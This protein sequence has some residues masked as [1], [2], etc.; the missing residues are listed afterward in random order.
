MVVKKQ[1]DRNEE[2]EIKTELHVVRRE[3]KKEAEK[4]KIR[5]ERKIEKNSNVMGHQY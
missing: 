4:E 2:K 3:E 5:K 1:K